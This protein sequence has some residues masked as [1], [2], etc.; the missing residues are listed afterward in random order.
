MK[1]DTRDLNKFIEE[2]ASSF[3]VTQPHL[4]GSGLG[5]LVRPRKPR[6]FH[7]SA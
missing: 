7:R 2:A 4:I 3:L 1:A 5:L 6:D